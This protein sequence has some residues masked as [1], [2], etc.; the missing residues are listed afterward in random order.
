MDKVFYYKNPEA[1]VSDKG[2]LGGLKIA[3]QPNISVAGWP[4]EAGSK[5][6][7]SYIALEDATIVQRLH[8][9]GAYL[10]GSTRMS[11]FGFGLQH[12][13]AGAALRQ[14]Y[15]DAELVL[16]LMGESRLAALRASMFGFKPSY[17]LVSRYGL[18]GLIPSMEC[19]GVLSSGLKHIREILKTIAGQD[20]LDF[21][22]PDE[23]LTDFSPQKIQAEKTTIG[24]VREALHALSEEQQKSFRSAIEELGGAG[25]SITEM[26]MPEFELFSLVHRIVG[27]VEASSSTGRYDSVRYGK[28][29]PGAKNWNEMYLLARREA[30]GQLLKSYIFQGA[31]FQF[32]QYGAFEDA[33]RIRAR[34][35]KEMHGFAVKADFL[36]FPLIDNS[37][38]AANASLED[39]YMQFTSTAFA[40]VTGQPSLYLPGT[41][42]EE[43][44][45]QMVGPRLSDVRLLA[46]GE[47]ILNHCRGDK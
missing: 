30:F 27:S 31:Y 46:L 47:Y 20:G 33:C 4:T 39:T 15:A 41:G 12:S 18:V 6:L 1:S 8:Q 3:I 5:A 13:K 14:K 44:G 19:C 29:V 42:K 38:L 11:E 2:N 22:L 35:L 17:G 25:F 23:E 21:S 16:D 45:F 9:A 37:P 32:E 10:C 28:R 36:A 26:S 24:V 7:A 40:N 34:L 43:R